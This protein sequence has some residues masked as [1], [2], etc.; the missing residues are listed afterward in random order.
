MDRPSETE[1]KMLKITL[2][3]HAKKILQVMRLVRDG[4]KKSYEILKKLE[5]IG[6]PPRMAQTYFSY[7]RHWGLILAKDCELTSLGKSIVRID[8]AK[9][10]DMASELVYYGCVSSKSFLTLGLLTQRLFKHLE[11]NGTF[12]FTVDEIPSHFLSEWK[13]RSGI[14]DLVN[15][16]HRVSILKRERRGGKWVYL[17]DY[18]EPSLGSFSISLLNYVQNKQ[19]SGPPYNIKEFDEFKAYWFMSNESFIKFLTQCRANG[20]ISYQKYA[21]VNQFQF[22]INDSAVLTEAV[23]KM[24]K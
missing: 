2:P 13:D 4:R 1:K 18:H 3:F 8:N 21:D 7:C 23:T 10:T 15:V 11:K 9:L 12:E 5:E 17:V 16:F 19:E 22:Y 14:S 20:W 6:W 24:K